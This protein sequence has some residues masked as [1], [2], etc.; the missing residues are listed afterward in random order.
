MTS[1]RSVLAIQMQ[2]GEVTQ[3]IASLVPISCFK[4]VQ[5]L[6]LE[7]LK[8]NFVALLTAEAEYMLLTSGALEAIWLKE[9]TTELDKNPIK[10]TVIYEDSQS[11][12]SMARNS[13]FHDHTE[14]IGMK[15]HYIGKKVNNRRVELKYRRNWLL[16]TYAYNNR[17]QETRRLITSMRLTA[18]VCLIERV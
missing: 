2:T 17:R 1:L 4:M 13:Q 3:I 18:S 14:H 9:L 5:W 15:F 8:A 16:S 11:T 6:S 12:L 10:L 7:Y